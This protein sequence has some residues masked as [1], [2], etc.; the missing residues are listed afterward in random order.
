MGLILWVAFGGFEGWISS[1]VFD[2]ENTEQSGFNAALFG[3]SG[4]VLGG[5]IM[6]LIS[7]TSIFAFNARCFAAAVASAIFVILI[8]KAYERRH[9]PEDAEGPWS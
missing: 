4:A 5:V 2:P 6:S 9:R 1:M 3:A 8:E 7:N